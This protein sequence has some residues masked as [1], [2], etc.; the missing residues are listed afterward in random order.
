MI[1]IIMPVYNE[2]EII[3]KSLSNLVSLSGKPEIIVIDGGSSDET[4]EKAS[5][6]ENVTV[7]Q[8]DGVKGRANQ[9]NLGAQHASGEILLFIHA[10]LT[11]P[12][13]AVTE[14]EGRVQNGFTAGG[15][16]KKYDPE[17]LMLS[18][19][20]RVMNGVRTRLLKNLVGTNG[21]FVTRALF[22]ELGGYPPV[23]LMEDVALSDQLKKKAR[24]AIL[25]GP[26][27]VSARKYQKQGPLKRI[28][29]ALKVLYLYR[30]RKRSPEQLKAIYENKK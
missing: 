24:L 14:I 22:D 2:G 8:K 3:Q 25:A 7:I 27:V 29:V 10:D 9:M 11:L 5:R 16:L 6:F 23:P 13:S 17:T 19:Y 28:W 26:I 1:S 12:A 18:F 30:I 21:I 4:V 20:R 15:F